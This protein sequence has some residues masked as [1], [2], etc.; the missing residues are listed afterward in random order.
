MNE[1]PESGRQAV[2][3]PGSRDMNETPASREVDT[4]RFCGSAIFL[5][6]EM[7]Y[8]RENGP[9]L[10]ARLCHPANRDRSIPLGWP[11]PPCESL[12]ALSPTQRLH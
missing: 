2:V 10:T 6:H 5:Q 11:C 7:Y 1:T 8:G 12:P 3:A 9:L 4:H